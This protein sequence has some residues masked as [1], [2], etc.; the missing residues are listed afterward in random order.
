MSPGGQQGR[1]VVQRDRPCTP[2]PALLTSHSR[3]QQRRY[4]PRPRAASSRPRKLLLTQTGFALER[5]RRP[6]VPSAASD[7]CWGCLT[8]PGHWSLGVTLGGS[9][10]DVPLSTSTLLATRDQPFSTNEQLALAGFLAGY[11]GLTREAY[12]LDLRQYVAWCTEHRVA[13]FGARR[14]DI[15]CFACHLES[16]GR[17]RATDRP[18]ALHGGLVVPLRRTGR[19]DRGLAGRACAPTAPGLRVPRHRPGSQRGRRHAGGRRVGRRSGS[20]VDQFAGAERAAG[21]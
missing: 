6:D 1:L 10:V 13:V 9:T 4:A 11:S 19:P 14:A 16:L 17:A 2:K 20:R 12:M 7:G 18:P 21:V 8:G 5:S 3:T 15:E